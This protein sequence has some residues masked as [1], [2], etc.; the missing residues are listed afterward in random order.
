M[1]PPIHQTL[2][3]FEISLAEQELQKNL[4]KDVFFSPAMFEHHRNLSFL[5]T[6]SSVSGNDDCHSLMSDTS[7]GSSSPS[8]QYVKIEENAS[9]SQESVFY[10][11]DLAQ[12]VP[13]NATNTVVL[14]NQDDG[15]G[16]IPS[17]E[18]IKITGSSRR[19]KQQIASNGSSSLKKKKTCN[20]D[21]SKLLSINNVNR[22]SYKNSKKEDSSD[23]IR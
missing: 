14:G 16:T 5:S 7:V 18:T 21:V 13:T 8:Y 20:K 2:E 11:L 19:T 1:V 17:L 22:K 12:S 3:E 4:V 9:T 15:L 6:C 10:G 23:A